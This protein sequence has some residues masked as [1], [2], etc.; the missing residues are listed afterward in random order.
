MDNDRNTHGNKTGGKGQQCDHRRMCQR[1]QER[2]DHQRD[3]GEF[4]H[5]SG[6]LHQSGSLFQ[7][8]I[9]VLVL[10]RMADLVRN[11]GNR[12][13]AV[14]VR[15]VAGDTHYLLNGI[16]VISCLSLFNCDAG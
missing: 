15:V 10:Q 8:R 1:N 16:I 2:G 14:G 7:F 5:N 13:Q 4:L 3:P 6:A 11:S 9:V 12:R